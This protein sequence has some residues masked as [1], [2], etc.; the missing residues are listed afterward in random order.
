MKL[1]HDCI[2][3]L[4][5]HIESETTINKGLDLTKIE[6]LDYSSDDI[7]YTALKLK[8]AGYIEASRRAA[9]NN[10]V[11]FFNVSSITWNGHHFLD[12]IRDVGVWKDTKN[13]LSKFSSVSIGFVENVSSQVI[14]NLIS[15]QMGLI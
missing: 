11:Y 12:N 13:I 14:S 8:D 7:M 3:D 15:K 5:L 1:N 9:D 10:V 6:L 2:R 4:M